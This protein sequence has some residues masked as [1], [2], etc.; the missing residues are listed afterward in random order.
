[1][2]FASMVIRQQQPLT[3]TSPSIPTSILSP[4]P[5]RIP[6]LP[7]NHTVDPMVAPAQAGEDATATV[8]HVLSTE[9]AALTN[10]EQIY[11]TERLA[12]GNIER[13]VTQI[14]SSI[15]R[16]G[17]LIVCGVGKSGR[18]GR[19]VEATMTSMGVYSVF[20]HPTEALHGDLGMIRLVC[21]GR[22]VYIFLGSPYSVR[23]DPD[24]G[25]R[26]IRFC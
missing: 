20:L 21:F 18:I 6:P 3:P 19:K 16:G 2:A 15:K 26:W 5:D 1:M 25:V 24:T 8:L 13:A 23:G 9:R 22:Y 17:K 14:V 12:Q 4:T 11:R 7:L 10:L